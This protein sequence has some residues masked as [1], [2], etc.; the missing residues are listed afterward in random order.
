METPV[1]ALF[2]IVLNDEFVAGLADA[3][4]G[5]KKQIRG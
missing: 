5:A 4:D 3:I 2:M 1:E